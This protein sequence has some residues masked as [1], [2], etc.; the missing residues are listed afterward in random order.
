MPNKRIVIY[1]QGAIGDLMHTLPL[2]KLIRKKNPVSRIEY[3]CDKVTTELLEK[4][5]DYIDKVW[6]IKNKD[7]SKIPTGADEFIYLHSKWWEALWINFSQVKASKL[8]CYRNT[9]HTSAVV[10]YVLTRYPELQDELIKDP[11]KV[12]EYKTLQSE[13]QTK[14]NYICIVPGVGKL[15]PHRAYPLQKWLDFI[16][17]QIKNTEQQIKILGG[18]DEADLNLELKK[19]LMEDPELNSNRIENLVGQTSLLEL[20]AI[21][22]NCKHLY[23]ADTGI[24]HIGAAAGAEI[25]SVFSITDHLRFGPFSPNAQN[26]SSTNCQCKLDT[27][28][29][30]HCKNLKEGYASC[31]WDI[32]LT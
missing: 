24:L 12:L 20:V 14:Q 15:R 1:R 19:K 31:I 22:S 18:P 28:K 4:S 27:G 29:K 13:T 17:V 9:P 3:A 7:F 10:N 5:C 2:V 23:S 32:E 21:L 26:Y 30:K 25:S 8:Y 16:K 11:Y 6:A